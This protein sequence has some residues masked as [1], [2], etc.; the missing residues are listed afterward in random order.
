LEF[1]K[2]KFESQ[3]ITELKEIKQGSSETVWDFDKRFKSLMEKLKF[4]IPA[5]QHKEWFIVALAPHIK[6]PLCQQK[7]ASQAESLE[8]YIRLEASPIG[9][10]RAGM[11]QVHL[12]LAALTLQVQDISK[13]K[14]KREDVR[15]TYCRTEGHYK[16]QCLV[17][18]QYMAIGAPN[19]VGLG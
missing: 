16:N 15:C 14:E 2:P 12:Q 8:A 9:E 1:K 17:L 11:A 3:C 19:L 5:Q 7:L 6:I 4:Q 18:L 13:Q 10:S